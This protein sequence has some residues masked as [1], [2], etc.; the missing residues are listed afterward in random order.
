[1][2]LPRALP[3]LPQRRESGSPL[4]RK[5]RR[6]SS[7]GQEAQIGIQEFITRLFS[8][9]HVQISTYKLLSLCHLKVL[10]LSLYLFCDIL[11]LTIAI[12]L[13]RTFTKFFLFQLC[14]VSLQLRNTFQPIS[15]FLSFSGAL[16]SSFFGV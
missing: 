10:Y 12:T 2:H 16:S 4:R 14:T 13:P 11:I 8:L 7:L 3:T 15:Q 6:S 9:L 5:R 1:M